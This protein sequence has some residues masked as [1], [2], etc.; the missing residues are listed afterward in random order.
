MSDFHSELHRAAA[1]HGD[2]VG[3]DLRADAVVA[4]SVDG[5]QR[6]RRRRAAVAGGAAAVAA[7]AVVGVGIWLVPVGGEDQEPA[8]GDAVHAGPWLYDVGSDP[9]GFPVTEPALRVSGERAVMC[10]DE[11]S[12]AAGVTVHDPDAYG[13]GLFF[14]AELT[15]LGETTDEVPPTVRQPVDPDNPDGPW[16]GWDPDQAFWDGTSG[17]AA[18]TATTIS[19]LMD[20]QTVVGVGQ[21]SSRT[22]GDRGWSAGGA[23]AHIPSE[24]A[25][26]LTG[27]TWEEIAALE[28][29]DP[30][31]TLVVTQF[32]SAADF[33]QG[34][35]L[36]ERVPLATIVVDPVELANTD[37]SPGQAL[38]AFV[39]AQEVDA[40]PAELREPDGFSHQ[41]FVVE[42][43]QPGCAPLSDLRR[44]GHPSTTDLEYSA[45]LGEVGTLDGMLW[46]AEPVLRTADGDDPWYVGRDAWLVA[47]AVSAGIEDPHL[48][49]TSLSSEP[50]WALAI[51][52]EDPLRDPDCAYVQPIP[53]VSGAVFLVIDGVDPDGAV[54]ATGEGRLQTWVYLGEATT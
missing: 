20:G 18:G 4:S 16:T 49:W 44:A 21:G 35:A 39:A 51:G 5:I 13:R 33:G 46:G 27:M 11:L 42:R 53:D 32:W 29:G 31:D 24:D 23:G 3:E 22:S 45:V 2:A 30:F 12:L 9:S 43:P 54:D 10:G 14:A 28:P 40:A 50:V 37:A 17:G 1:P 15:T 19:L 7:V 8:G 36:D 34:T 52:G 26:D 41:A 38:D 48:E 25:C 47:D 6:G